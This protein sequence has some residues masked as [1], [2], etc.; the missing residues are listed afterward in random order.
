M[1]KI[2]FWI[3]V[4]IIFYTY[5][6]YA[7]FLLLL[8]GL[9]RLFYR[10][11]DIQM[12][13]VDYPEVTILIAAY[14]E[15]DTIEAKVENTRNINYPKNKL[16]VVWITDGSDDGTPEMLANFEE[17]K[18]LHT[19]ERK[20]KTTALNRAMQSIH[21]PF[22]IFSDANTMLDPDAIKKL[23]EPFGNKKV[24]CVAGEKRI[25]NNLFEAAAGAGEG[26]YWQYESILKKLESNFQSVLAA[27]GELYAIRTDLYKPVDPDIIIDDFVISLNIARQGYQIKYQ[28][29][30]YAMENSSANIREELKRKIRIASGAIQVLFR[31]P[32]L[33]NIFRH[34]FLSFEFISHKVLRWL[35][36]PLAIPLIAGFTI[37]ICIQS[38]WQNPVY[39]VI[40][41][42]QVLF[43]FLVL[44]GIIFEG[45]AT[46]MK[47][48]YLPFYLIIF[49]FAQYAGIFR[50]F[51]GKHNVVWEKAKRAM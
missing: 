15:K 4:I 50:F 18:V 2:I 27:A 31:Y 32:S 44:L 36:V 16:H 23:I 42:I 46:R 26:A 47:I 10:P 19:T 24:G 11:N 9:K 6:G 41:Y 20:G 37:L 25:V 39:A 8:N 29:E 51:R 22:T 48:L 33:L 43:Y 28:P 1:L 21:T 3:L 34:G 17:I 5:F 45:K 30:A 7:G 35:I 49:N 12:K 14:N 38:H 13:V 40:F